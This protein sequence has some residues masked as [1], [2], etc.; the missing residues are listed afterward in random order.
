VPTSPLS[1]AVD[2][3]TTSGTT[4]LSADQVAGRLPP[5]SETAGSWATHHCPPARLGPQKYTVGLIF[6]N[7]DTLAGTVVSLKG[8]D[9]SP[10]RLRLSDH[11]QVADGAP[12]G[13]VKSE[14]E[15]VL[16]DFL[17]PR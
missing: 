6:E 11:V 10:R 13:K 17:G 7:A 1:K 16:G 12:V 5:P 2:L 8:F 15:G 9:G 14:I 4:D 3:G